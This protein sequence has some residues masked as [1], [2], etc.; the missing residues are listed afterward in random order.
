MTIS[1]DYFIFLLSALVSFFSYFLRYF[2]KQISVLQ[3]KIETLPCHNTCADI[4]II[5]NDISWIKLNL[6]DE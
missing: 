5:K 1:N 3:K 2:I 6:L 4:K